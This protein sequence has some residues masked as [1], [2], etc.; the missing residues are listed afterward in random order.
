MERYTG[1]AT[2]MRVDG[3]LVAEVIAR[4]WAGWTDHEVPARRWG[5]T[6]TWNRPDD[7]ASVDAG[8]GFVLR[9]PDGRAGRFRVS[10]TRRAIAIERGGF[11]RSFDLLG[12]EPSPFGG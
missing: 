12:I 4:V 5:G 10:R 9:L 8:D 1:P 2:V 11:R 6:L 3:A 7:L